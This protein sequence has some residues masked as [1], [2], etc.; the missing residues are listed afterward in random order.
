M[1]VQSSSAPKT[2]TLPSMTLEKLRRG[3]CE[4]KEKYKE[5]EKKVEL[6]THRN[7]FL[8]IENTKLKNDNAQLQGIKNKYKELI[9]LTN[10]DL[11]SSKTTLQY[12][13][14]IAGAIL[15]SGAVLVSPVGAAIALS[16]AGSAV[17]T[18]GAALAGGAAGG[19]LVAPFVHE[20][21]H[22]ELIQ[23]V[24]NFREQE[25]TVVNQ[26]SELTISGNN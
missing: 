11:Q 18:A 13:Y 12:T 26:T 10:K 8:E 5:S 6:L 19:C 15:G 16:G 22:N 4:L 14:A 17:V 23:E 7:N 21:Q 2:V 25:E 1:F 3:N 20:K 24:K 9:Q